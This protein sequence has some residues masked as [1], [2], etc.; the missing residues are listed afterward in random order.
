GGLSTV[1]ESVSEKRAIHITTQQQVNGQP[2][3]STR[4]RGHGRSLSAID[5]F[6]LCPQEDGMESSPLESLQEI[7]SSMRNLPNVPH[8]T[9]GHTNHGDQAQG[10]G[11][12][13]HERR[14]SASSLSSK[15]SVG[16]QSS[17]TTTTLHISQ[18]PRGTNITDALQ[19]T[20]A[21][22]RRLSVT[23]T[24][25]PL[26]SLKEDE[27]E[28]A[29]TSTLGKTNRRRSATVSRD[30]TTTIGGS[31]A[32][33]RRTTISSGYQPNRRS[34]VIRPE[35]I[36]ALQEG[37]PYSPP[38]F[39]FA[40][41]DEQDVIADTLSTL[42]GK[43]TPNG[44]HSSHSGKGSHQ[45][46]VSNVD[47][48]SLAEFAARLPNHMKSGG[49]GSA[50]P[51]NNDDVQNRRRFTTALHSSTVGPSRAS[52]ASN[53]RLSGTPA[54]RPRRDSVNV[55]ETANSRRS[56]FTAHLLYLEFHTLSTK[57]RHNYVQGV[58]RISKRN[59]S[60]AYVTVD[61]LPD[62]DVY[63]CGSKDRNRA[64]EGDVVGIELF[65]PE[66]LPPPKLESNKD[67]RRARP[68]EDLDDVDNADSD[69]FK[70]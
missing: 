67:E 5:K 9:T 31:S 34:V 45:R 47:A 20:V 58:L 50:A 3:L 59:R 70:P 23:D 32:G 37:N 41:D 11:Y 10:H 54:G 65:D 15:S 28:T 52:T 6:T 69:E 68:T 24:K 46:S 29:T 49:G 48:Y 2:A 63:I 64:L 57:H 43:G 22:L 33:N 27:G 26:I 61:T 42:E 62:G 16:P 25:R 60:D 4:R 36:T 21:T 7:I 38:L 30:T 44:G 66:E 14:L 55:R 56:L 35:E 40:S 51:V 12:S 53:R 17:V 18:P 8:P 19:S 1:E 39:S 13:R